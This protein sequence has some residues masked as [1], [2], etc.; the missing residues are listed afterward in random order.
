[1]VT[2]V[3][4]Y[5]TNNELVSASEGA[6]PEFVASNGLLRAVADITPG[7]DD[8][9]YDDVTF[10]VPYAAFP[11]GLS[12]DVSFF[13][14]ADVFDGENWIAPS[15]WMELILT[16]PGGDTTNQNN[17][18]STISVPGVTATCGNITITDGVE[19]I[20]RQMRP[21]FNYTA[22]A[23][24]IGGFDPVLI[25][26]DTTDINDMLCNDDD[27]NAAKFQMNLPS[28]GNVG[29]SSTSSQVVFNHSNSSMTDISLIV[30]SF[31]GSPGEFVLVLEGMAVTRED[32]A[33]DPFTLNGT[34]SMANSAVPLSVYMIGTERQL[35][36]Y[37]S[38]VDYPDLT[39]WTDTDNLQIYCDDAGDSNICWDTAGS[40]NGYQ[41]GRGSRGVITADAQDAM[42]TLPVQQ[43]NPQPM[44]F[45][46]SSYDRSTT[47]QYLIAFHIG[48]N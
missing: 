1:M 3:F 17:N 30:G 45:L 36:P 8:T 47:G 14:E 40:L 35:D 18:Q 13:A 41:V 34:S 21:G 32:N 4:F 25:V 22:T 6:D 37:F 26:R 15:E 38:V 11:T 9:E 28:T 44:T 5:D 43:L 48:L 29:A 7:F 23:V 39:I 2:G 33:G 10:W 20:V 42:L 27:S 46:M 16:Y 24:G 19:I 31:D 12:G